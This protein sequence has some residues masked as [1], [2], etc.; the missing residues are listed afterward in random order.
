MREGENT[1]DG[2]TKTGWWE[3]TEEIKGKKIKN[4]NWLFN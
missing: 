4:K 3:R 2:E 1:E